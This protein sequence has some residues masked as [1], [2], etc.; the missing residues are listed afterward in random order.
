MRPDELRD[1]LIF[2]HG[3]DPLFENFDKA[4]FLKCA[5]ECVRD[6]NALLDLTAFADRLVD[7]G[8]D[9]L[10]QEIGRKIHAIIRGEKAG[11]S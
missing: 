1:E 7:C 8:H 6:F 10:Q 11:G 4:E 9:E 3:S 5:E 2:R